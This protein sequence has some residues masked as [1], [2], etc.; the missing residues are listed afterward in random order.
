MCSIMQTLQRPSPVVFG[1]VL[2][3]RV[4]THSAYRNAHY[5]NIDDADSVHN[6]QKQNAEMT[7]AMSHSHSVEIVKIEPP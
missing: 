4:H 6:E 2:S 1:A 5:L 3:T 7:C